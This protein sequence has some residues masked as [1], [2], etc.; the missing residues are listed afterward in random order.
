MVYFACDPHFLI[1]IGCWE[2]DAFIKGMCR[3]GLQFEVW[4]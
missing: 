3:L 4:K 1:A 2:H